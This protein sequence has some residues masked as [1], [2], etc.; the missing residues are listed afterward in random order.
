MYSISYIICNCSET[1]KKK[2]YTQKNEMKQKYNHNF[3][4]YNHNFFST[5]NKMSRVSSRKN[6]RLLAEAEAAKVAKEA[7]PPAKVLLDYFIYIHFNVLIISLRR[8]KEKSQKKNQMKRPK[9]RKEERR[10]KI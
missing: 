6:P 9:T 7:E 5:T 10:P 8:V 3:Q 4:K 2:I 1:K